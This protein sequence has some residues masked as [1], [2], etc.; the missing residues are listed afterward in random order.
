MSGR[1]PIKAVV[2]ERKNAKANAALAALVAQAG[3]GKDALAVRVGVLGRKANE[4]HPDAIALEVGKDGETLKPAK[5]QDGL[6]NVQLAAIHEFGAPRAG[7]PERSFI[8]ATI[9]ANRSTY[10]A[11]VIPRLIKAVV[12]ARSSIHRAFN[13]LGLKVVADIKNRIVTGAGVP[14]P[15]KPATIAA[16]GSDRPLVDTGRLLGAITHEVTVGDLVVK[17]KDLV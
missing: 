16:K 8:R 2:R 4:K 17:S 10:R 15:L 9:D 5:G 13:L 7:V 11:E 6:T 12:E 14:P 3:K 1:N